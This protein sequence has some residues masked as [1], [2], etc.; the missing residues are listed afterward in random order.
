[1]PVIAGVLVAVAIFFVLKDNGPAL[2]IGCLFL[3][4]YAIARKRILGAV[5]GFP[6][7]ALAFYGGHKLRFPKTV[8]DRVD[9]WESPWRNTVSGG[10]Q[11]AH[12]VWALSTGASTGTGLGLGSPST[13]P[14]GHTD[15]ILSAAGEEL[16]FLGLLGIFLLYGVLAWRSLRIALRARSPYSYFL[17][18]GLTLI[19]TLQLILMAGGLVGLL[20]LSGVVSPFLSFGRTSMVANF[21]T[22][23]II[24]A[25][26]SHGGD[27]AQA[28]NFGH[29]TYLMAGILGL[30]G[31]AILGRAAYFQLMRPDQFAIKGAEVRFA[32][33]SLGLEY[34]PRLREILAQIPKGDVLDRNGLPLA[35]N[36]WATLQRHSADY[37][38]LGVSIDQ[39]T[40]RNESRHYPLGP[41]FFSLVVD[42]R[43]KWRNGGIRCGHGRPAGRGQVA[44][45]RSVAV[46]RVP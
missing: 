8:A 36:N 4:L 42:Q 24:L 16:G 28:R 1:M 3:I 17:A 21:I 30:C 14:A 2:V 12:S 37:Q 25:V 45:A 46:R 35:T 11:I 23:A 44:M 39:T 18:A 7:I 13:L 22:L 40:V 9:M 34:N 15:L 5:V 43:Q 19:F 26:S 33:K 32:D 27:K 38:R 41:E 20:P 31:M 10:D 6:I 29:S